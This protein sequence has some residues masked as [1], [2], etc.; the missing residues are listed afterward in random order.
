VQSTGPDLDTVPKLLIHNAARLGSRPAMRYK[1]LGIWQAWTWAQMLEE[2]RAFS[3]GLA[4]L[5]VKRGDKFAIIGSNRPR[6]YWAMCAGQALGAVP[7]PVY[8]DAVA[9]EMAFV[10]AHAE[11]TLAMVE[12]QEQ[13]D[14]LIGIAE[15]LP[16][17]HQVI[18]D[19]PRGLKDY[20][21]GRLTAFT[22]VQSIGRKKLASDPECLK[23]W[24]AGVAEGKGSDLSVI[25]YTSG[26]TGHPKGVMLSYAN[27]IV[28][29]RNG[30]A[31]DG[32]GP[33]DDVIAYLPMAWVGDHILSYVQSYVGGF[34]VN[35][36]ETLDTVVEDRR[37]IGTTYAF[38]P[39]R[40]YEN[41]LTLTM[42]RMA[43]A[44]PF[45]R[46]L[47]DFFIG[48]AR[49]WGEK[50]LN[51]EKV[52]VHARLL[53]GIGDLLVYGPLKNRFGIS[54][55]RVAYTAGEAIGPE[56]FRF[57]RG[58]GLNL[59]QLY[60]QTEASVYVTAQPDGEIEAETVGR[61][62]P[63]VE[64]KI[65]DSG[66]VLYRSP[67]VFLGYYKDPEKTAEVRTPDGW[68]HSGDAG[69]FDAKTGH[70]K[71]I[72]RAKDVGRLKDGTLFAPK[73]MENKLKFYPNIREAVAVGADRDFVCAMINIDLTAVGSWAERNNAVYASYQELA[74][75]PLVY[76]MIAQH[77]DEVNRSLSEEEV[78]AGAQIRRF[79]IL[80]KELD[81]DD[82]ELTR[83]QKLRRGHIIDRYSPL[84][85]AFY[86]GSTTA[87]I[88]TEVTFDDG[89]KGVIA[90]RLAIRDM[91]PYPA[92]VAKKMERAA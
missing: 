25:L 53:Y 71:I 40:V 1:D 58:V 69:F 18:Y 27:A 47:F 26:T 46:K 91:R 30:N 50:I 14:K 51:G 60:G 22:E 84:V 64:V 82:G 21:H 76:D 80:H 38:A 75:H 23:Q 35:C 72:D 83:T 67:G 85:D 90:A 5:G 11:V 89:H 74:A 12:D 33:D 36:P 70:L 68:V 2:I 28:S 10:L 57:W 15:R 49:R 7:V 32:L 52:P 4:E 6:L 81:A 34:C 54:R 13:V 43:D 20:D 44:G 87:Q 19:E 16:K 63:D 55:I 66:E 48:V 79:L 77:V 88:A 61:P 62:S 39:P 8:A 31:F 59:K 86:N 17:L 3:I 29:S 65:S 56:I 24:E 78:M 41:N 45:K 92:P 37:E 9:D 73:Y 42:V